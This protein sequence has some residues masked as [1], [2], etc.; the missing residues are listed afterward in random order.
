M[1]PYQGKMMA[2][3]EADTCRMYVLPK[4]R[5]AGWTDDQIREQKYFTDGRI[6]MAGR[7]HL[8]RPGKKADYLLHYRADYRLAVLEA[9]ASYKKPADGLQQAMEYAE[10][11]GL[12]FAYATNGHGIVENDYITGKQ[13]TLDHFPSPVTCGS[14]SARAKAWLTKRWP[15][16]CSF[17]STANSAIRTVPSRRP[18]NSKRS[19]STVPFRLSCKANLASSSPWPRGQARPS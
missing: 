11:L 6:V 5:E 12:K 8:R 16:T 14:D 18:G 19:P 3:T 2:I 1:A 17:L 13:Q 7:K 4:L 9:K 10:I 15:K